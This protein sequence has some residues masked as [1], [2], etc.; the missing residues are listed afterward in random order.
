MPQYR[1]YL[2]NGD[3]IVGPPHDLICEND[4][5]ATTMARLFV[6]DWDIEIWQLDRLV[7]RLPRRTSSK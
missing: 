6:L 3:H 7:I 1:V 5:D 4:D 2:M